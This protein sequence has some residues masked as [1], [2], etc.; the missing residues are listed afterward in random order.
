MIVFTLMCGMVS[1]SRIRIPDFEFRILN[2]ECGTLHS[3]FEIRLKSNFDPDS[4]SE[5]A[6]NNMFRLRLK[7]PSRFQSE[8]RLKLSNRCRFWIVIFD[9]HFAHRFDLDFRF[10]CNAGK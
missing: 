1:I 8:Y 9:L 3:N 2:F 4:N 10:R 5:F 6:L 7:Y